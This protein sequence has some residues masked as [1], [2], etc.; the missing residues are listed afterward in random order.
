[1]HKL[2][3]VNKINVGVILLLSAFMLIS[4]HA[5]SDDDVYS[6]RYDTIDVDTIF[7]SN[8]LLNNYVDCLLDK[9]SCPPEM[10]DLKRKLSRIP[11]MMCLHTKEGVCHNMQIS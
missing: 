4:A 7:I 5:E 6:K 8:R 11:T 3:L 10:K 9:K 1:M 2:W